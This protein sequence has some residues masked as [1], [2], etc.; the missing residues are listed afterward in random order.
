VG[1]LQKHDRVIRFL[2]ANASVTT[3]QWSGKAHEL[4]ELGHQL[5]TKVN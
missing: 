5:K 2:P 1:S 4:V 3:V